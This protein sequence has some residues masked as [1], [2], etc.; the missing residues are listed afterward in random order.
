[1]VPEE[2]AEKDFSE[3]LSMSLAERQQAEN[4]TGSMISADGLSVDLFA[5]EPL[6][7]N[8]TNI[9]VDERGRVWDFQFK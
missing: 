4:A 6:V 8:P 5:G 3:Y 2:R 1:M 7:V 9:A